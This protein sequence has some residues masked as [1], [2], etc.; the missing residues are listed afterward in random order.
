MVTIWRCPYLLRF[1]LDMS[2]RYTP[3]RHARTRT[4]CL[5][6]NGDPMRR[7][8]D[9]RRAEPCVSSTLRNGLK[10]IV[11]P[12][13]FQ[14]TGKLPLSVV[15]QPA[16]ALDRRI[17]PS[18]RHLLF[19]EVLQGRDH[20][21][22]DLL[23][24]NFG[25]HQV[26]GKPHPVFLGAVLCLFVRN[27]RIVD[28]KIVQSRQ[29]TRVVPSESLKILRAWIRLELKSESSVIPKSFK[30]KIKSR[31]CRICASVSPGKPMMKNP[32]I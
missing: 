13:P 8:T 6:R 20:V 14:H 7:S 19:A 32:F 17:A 25:N 23:A 29:Y 22:L 18:R 3:R 30:R 21:L 10:E 16:I 27:A 28:P 26:I 11:P 5:A 1:P 12:P 15:V 31:V 4:N 24:A 2:R 9:R